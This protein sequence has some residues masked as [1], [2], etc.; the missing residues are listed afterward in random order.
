VT[1]AVSVQLS[2]KYGEAEVISQNPLQLLTLAERKHGDY[3]QFYMDKCRM[4]T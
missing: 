4:A 3:L 2:I 1:S